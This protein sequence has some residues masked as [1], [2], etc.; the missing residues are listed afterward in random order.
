MPLSFKK[1]D[2]NLGYNNATAVNDLDSGELAGA[3]G[4]YYKTGSDD[5]Y[6]KAGRTAFSATAL[7]AVGGVVYCEFTDATN[8]IFVRAGNTFSRA[9]AALT[10]TYTTLSSA[11]TLT[12]LGLWST[13]HSNKYYFN[14]GAN[15]PW[16]IQYVAVP[17]SETAD[18]LYRLAGLLPPTAQPV[19]QINQTGAAA[20]VLTT[21]D[22]TTIGDKLFTGLAAVYDDNLNSGATV[23]INNA[24]VEAVLTSKN[25]TGT[26]SGAREDWVLSLTY[27]V[28][29]VNN[30]PCN[31][32]IQYTTDAGSNWI[33]FET[34][35][36]AV[37]KKTVLFPFTTTY[38]SANLGWRV[39]HKKNTDVGRSNCTVYDTRLFNPQGVGTAANTL[40][41]GVY[42]WVT[43]R[44]D[45][46]G[47]SSQAGPVSLLS[48][49]VTTAASIGVSLPSAT[50]NP[51]T[52]HYDIWR[53]VDGG[54]FPV[55]ALAGSVPITISTFYD[56]GPLNQIAGTQ[57]YGAF[58]VGGIYYH[59]DVVPPVAT[60]MTTY[61]NC[62]VVAPVA[63]PNQL[64]YSIASYSDSFP[65]INVIPLGSS[66]DDTVR[67]LVTLSSQL[68]VFCAGRCRRI[69][70]LPT[71]SDPTFAIDP[72]DFAPDH[73]IES[74]NGWCY[75]NPPNGVHSH[76]AYVARDGI[77]ITDLYT[78]GIVTNN[79][80]WAA[81]VDAANLSTCYLRNNA[82]NN[83]IEFYGVPSEA[84]RIEQ[85][86]L[87]GTR[88]AMWL[89][90]QATNN[91]VAGKMRTTFHPANAA[92]AECVPLGALDYIFT[93]T[94]GIKR[95]P[96]QLFVDE[97]GTAD[98]TL[99]YTTTG[100]VAR[101][102][103]TGQ[104][105]AD[106]S[107]M[108]RGNLE[109]LIVDADGSTQPLAITVTAGRD[110]TGQSWSVTRDFLN[111]VGGAKPLWFHLSG[112][113]HQVTLNA[114]SS[115]TVPARL[116]H[117]AWTTADYGE[118]R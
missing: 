18:Y 13:F 56:K 111:T 110:D 11:L 87:S 59:R 79:L 6:F 40:V 20:I 17:P 35:K 94:D 29:L 44:V 8:Q 1:Y 69:D 28:T 45:Y 24:G 23:A 55:G 99:S 63:F 27:E 109:R 71:S 31:T 58:T 75:L 82:A 102:I 9:A 15:P 88:M 84:F 96:G 3:V 78:T 26:S 48:G 101:R 43:E 81:T 93:L 32:I 5:C 47:I 67:A 64:R 91:A 105:Y 25:F 34:V 49:P 10:G 60:V 85:G 103:K 89:H 51:N 106:E 61:Q 73:G 115:T 57:T 39:R 97:V 86:W 37:T 42:Y 104:V 74:R 112:H 70:H 16:V 98:A 7:G 118:L 117:F 107:R 72:Q 68:G 22:V 77:R 46:L 33:T 19:L 108:G 92:A 30:G 12:P 83:R 80:N 66:R 21:S 4:I 54:A 95:P 53:T 50:I 90:Y 65:T 52:T 116:T 2:L 14:D 38:D 41:T 76:I 36:N 113:W 62:V 100:V 114:D